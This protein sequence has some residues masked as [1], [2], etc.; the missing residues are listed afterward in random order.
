[1]P[2]GL[3]GAYRRRASALYKYTFAIS[4]KVEIVLSEP[5]SRPRNLRKCAIVG[6]RFAN[7]LCS[8]QGQGPEKGSG[9]WAFFFFL[10]LWLSLLFRRVHKWEIVNRRPLYSL[11]PMIHKVRKANRSIPELRAYSCLSHKIR[12]TICI[13]SR[14]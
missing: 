2:L 14:Y 6:L 13:E 5:P 1:M 7:V 12:N 11:F 8:R 4:G 10:R 9:R 3:W